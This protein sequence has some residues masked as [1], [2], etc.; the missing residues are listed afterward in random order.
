M[1]CAITSPHAWF[2][3]RAAKHC[4]RPPWP[5]LGRDVAALWAPCSR[6]SRLN[7]WPARSPADASPVSSRMPMH[8]SG[9]MRIA[10]PSSRWTCTTYSLPVPRRTY[11]ITHVA[12]RVGSLAHELSGGQGVS[13]SSGFAEALVDGPES[14]RE[15]ALS[16]RRLLRRPG[17]QRAGKGGLPRSAGFLQ[18]RA[19]GRARGIGM[20]RAWT[21]G[22]E[23]RVANTGAILPCPSM[24]PTPC[25]KL[26][27]CERALASHSGT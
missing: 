18:T 6:P 12:R 11:L 8:E 25:E 7:G 21:P 23:S 27:R 17:R 14:R 26:H 20:R 1:T 22:G 5:Q 13:A 15:R 19:S 4:P 16:H 3:T 9:S 24:T 10:T 2:S